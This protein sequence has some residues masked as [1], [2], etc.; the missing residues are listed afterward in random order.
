MAHKFNSLPRLIQLILLLIPVVGWVVE[1]VV[2]ISAVIERTTLGNILGLIFGIII[3]VF[4]WLDL[5][6]VLL[7]KHMILLNA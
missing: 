7:F 2:R 5:V 3:P 4:G 1:V 6:W